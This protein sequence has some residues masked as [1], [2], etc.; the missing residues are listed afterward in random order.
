VP[1]RCERDNQVHQALVQPGRSRD[2]GVH[3]EEYLTGLKEFCDANGAQLHYFH[4]IAHWALPLIYRHEAYRND[5]RHFYHPSF[6][7]SPDMPCDVVRSSVGFDTIRHLHPFNVKAYCTGYCVNVK[8]YEQVV[9]ID[10]DAFL[11]WRLDE[12]LNRMGPDTII[13]F[14]DGLEELRHLEPL[15]GVSRP[16]DFKNTSYAFNAGVVF[17]RNGEGVHALTLDFMHFIESCHHFAFSGTFADQGVLRALVA[18]HHLLGRIHFELRDATNWNPTWG[19][20]D[21]LRF[22]PDT[23]EWINQWN[24]QRQYIWHGAGSKKLW[25]GRYP[26]EAVNRAWAFIGGEV[27]A[28][29]WSDVTGSLIPA[30]CVAMCDLIGQH[31][32]DATTLRILEIGTQYGRTAIAMCR[33]LAE[34]GITAHVDTCDIFAPSPD[35]PV[36]FARQSIVLQNIAAFGLGT[37]ITSHRVKENEN[38]IRKFEEGSFDVVFID[39]NHQFKQVLADCVVARRLVK[40]DGLIIGDDWHLPDVRDACRLAF[41]PCELLPLGRHMWFVAPAH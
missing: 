41:K 36:A 35:Y 21:N 23:E 15:Y 29:R 38:L 27:I 16:A 10:A 3:R 6:A 2:R 31:H 7:S 11:L 20:A 8:R 34:R 22:V 28:S 26:S 39:A 9:Y 24:G 1:G 14:D 12:L 5:T 4:Q 13:A 32:P 25:T 17:Y 30:N 37:Q 40:K 19:R 33:L 18:K